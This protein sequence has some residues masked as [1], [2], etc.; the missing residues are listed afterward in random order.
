[1]TSQSAPPPIRDLTR[2]LRSA[3][4]H[5]PAQAIL[6]AARERNIPV[7]WPDGT[8]DV[9]SG[10]E[11]LLVDLLLDRA[12]EPDAV[13]PP[14]HAGYAA[15]SPGQRTAFHQWCAGAT[16]PAPRA[17][18]QL[19]LANLE[20]QLFQPDQ[21]DEAAADLAWLSANN[22]WTDQVL[23]HRVMLLHLWLQ[24]D[25]QALTG[26]SI[27]ARQ[28][29]ADVW[30]TLLGWQALLGQPLQA[31]QME[32]L[33]AAWS[34]NALP[35]LTLIREM[36]GSDPLAAALSDAD[37]DAVMPKPWRGVHPAVR[38]ALPQPS[39]RLSLTRILQGQAQAPLSAGLQA[40]PAPPAPKEEREEQN[41]PRMQEEQWHLILEFRQSRSDYFQTALAFAQREQSFAQ[42][43]DEKRN[44]VYRVMF[45]KDKLRNFWRLWNIVENW[46]GVR[47][48]VRGQEVEKRH[49]WRYSQHL[50]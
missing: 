33:R 48:Y 38:L 9:A 4:H 10:E 19:L 2:R 31:E 45:R 17:F 6:R 41:A 24:Q 37:E 43:L 7:A 5:L 44:V 14:P 50:E 28:A 23:L 18:T 8:P 11:T 20:I 39:L 16:A 3:D 49:V 25:G 15:F 13:P 22:A 35:R 34:L 40:P 26:W 36:T 46:R 29:K 27:Q 42:L 47:V 32:P 21:A 12:H 1:M 30:E